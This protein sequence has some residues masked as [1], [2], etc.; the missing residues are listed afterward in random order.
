MI[1]TSSSLAFVAAVTVGGAASAT[2]TFTDPDFLSANWAN[3]F[4][5]VVGN[6]GSYTA[7]QEGGVGNPG[8]Y[9]RVMHMLADAPAMENSGIAVLHDCTFMVYDP[10]VDGAIGRVYASL[11]VRKFSTF[12]AQ[13]RIAAVQSGALYV[14]TNPI[15]GSS[16]TNNWGSQTRLFEGAESWVLILPG[17]EIDTGSH[18]DFSALGAPISF[19]LYTA[20]STGVG[21][22]G[23]NTTVGIDNLQI[24]MIP[25]CPGDVT[26]AGGAPDGMVDVDDLNA[27]LSAWGTSVGVGSPLDLANDD[28]VIDVDDLN[29][30]LSNW[31]SNCR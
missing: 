25:V 12:T 3:S 20:N 21:F 4:A 14:S 15:M 11:D 22:G 26:G 1:R 9:Y 17:L 10:S 2:V 31:G 18:P 24:I 5:S 13:V 7:G 6:G 19:G 23:Y 27:I 28:G 30:V 8:D 16:I 29:V